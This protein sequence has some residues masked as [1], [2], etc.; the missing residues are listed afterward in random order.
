MQRPLILTTPQM[1]GPDVEFAQRLLKRRG[2][3]D[4]EITGEFA[5]STASA[6]RGPSRGSALRSRSCSRGRP[7]RQPR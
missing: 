4:G 7:S 2:F 6:M 3:Y 1:T 5:R